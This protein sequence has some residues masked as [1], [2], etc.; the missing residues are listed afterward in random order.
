MLISRRLSLGEPAVVGVRIVRHAQLTDSVAA[1]DLLSRAQAQADSL[2]LNAQAQR[3]QILDVALTEFWEEAGAFLQTLRAEYQALQD[4][5]I[6]ASRRVVNQVIEQVF[7]D[8]AT[9]DRARALVS[10]LA[11]SQRYASAASLNCH[12]EL[13]N[14]VQAWIMGSRFALVWQLREDSSLP[15]SALRLTSGS[16]DF[17]LDWASLQRCVQVPKT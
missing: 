12:P 17:E 11:A 9:P 8:C 1:Q 4:D 13:F 6:A 10:H 14:D 15:V 2:L 7:D 16:G 5:V 3:Q